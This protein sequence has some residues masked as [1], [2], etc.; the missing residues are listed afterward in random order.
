MLNCLIHVIYVTMYHFFLQSYAEKAMREEEI[1]AAK[2]AVEESEQAAL[3]AAAAELAGRRLTP[4]TPDP[5][6]NDSSINVALLSL[7]GSEKNSQ[8]HLLFLA[9]F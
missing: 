2:R 9:N 6:E 7:G 4:T 1:A 3:D 8:V 5:P